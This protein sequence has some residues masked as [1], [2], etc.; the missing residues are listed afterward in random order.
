MNARGAVIWNSFLKLKKYT[1]AGFFLNVKWK[2]G[3]L[4]LKFDTLKHFKTK[5]LDGK[6]L[7]FPASFC[8]WQILYLYENEAVKRGYFES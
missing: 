2:K 4:N 8:E 5:V 6:A 7:S 3:Y 1:I